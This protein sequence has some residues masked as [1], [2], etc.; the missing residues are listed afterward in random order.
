MDDAAHAEVVL[1]EMSG[2]TLKTIQS[3]SDEELFALL[4]K[5]L[6]A[7]IG[8]RGKAAE[9]AAKIRNLPIGL[10]AMAATYELDVSLAL[11][12]LGWHFGNWHDAA[13]A[14]E[15]SRGL[16]EL[17]ATDLAAIFKEG[18][19]LAIR[20]WNELGSS[21][22]TKWYNDSPL[23][24]AMKP[25]NDKAWSILNGKKKGIFDYWVAYARKHP[26]RIGV[27]DV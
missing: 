24:K 18:F 22:W 14:E 3:I 20:H 25:L 19:R 10:R 1:H 6:E 21:K 26:D 5:E 27:V 4:G 2:L 11:D 9:F 7:R 8:R 12:D 23:E 13:L 15:T 16:E 17:G